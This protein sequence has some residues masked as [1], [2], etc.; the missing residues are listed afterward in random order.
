[1][2]PKFSIQRAEKWK[3]PSIVFMEQLVKTVR[4]VEDDNIEEMWKEFIFQE[5]IVKFNPRTPFDDFDV[6]GSFS[7]YQV[8]HIRDQH[9]YWLYNDG[10]ATFYWNHEYN[11]QFQIRKGDPGDQVLDWLRR[12][13]RRHD[14]FTKADL[15]K[16]S[17]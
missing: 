10:V 15:L 4:D 1:M 3:P 12:L 9:S 2:L 5:R 16:G 11:F 17:R 7:G 13:V 14:F 6:E 8:K